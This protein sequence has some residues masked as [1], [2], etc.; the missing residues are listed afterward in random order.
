M[1]TI[2]ETSLKVILLS[3]IF[4][5]AS[6]TYSE[7]A[8]IIN[9]SNSAPISKEEIANIYLG[10]IKFF[11]NGDAVVPLDHAEGSD[12]RKQF[13][14]EVV[15]KKEGQMKSYWSRL[16]FTGQGVPP[17]VLSNDADIVT[18]VSKNPAGIGYVNSSSVNDKVKVIHTIK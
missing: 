15:G 14:D 17:Q 9:A 2:L 4:T 10:K 8:V 11:P 6:N 3:A 7:V 5:L 16:I 13:L 18:E 1:K 12:I